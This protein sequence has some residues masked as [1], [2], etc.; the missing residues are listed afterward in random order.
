[1]TN[2]QIA[3]IFKL[4]GA[5]LELHGENPFKTKSYNNAYISLRKVGDPLML[6]SKDQL[7]LIPGVGKAIAEK[8]LEIQSTDTF[9]L[10]EELKMKTPPGVVELLGISGLGPKK[11]DII[12]KIMGIEDPGAL[13]YACTENR[14]IEYK[15]FGAKSQKTIEEKLQFYF[16]S[17]GK[18]LYPDALQYVNDLIAKLTEINTEGFIFTVGALLRKEQ[19]I[20]QIELLYISDQ[21]IRIPDDFLLRPLDNNRYLL[22][23][24]NHPE[25]F[26]NHLALNTINSDYFANLLGNIILE[27]VQ[28][29]FLTDP[30]SSINFRDLINSRNLDQFNNELFGPIFP[31]NSPEIWHNPM[32]YQNEHNLVKREDL[33][34]LVHLHTTYSDGINTLEEMIEAAIVRNFEYIV[35]TDHSKFAFYANGLSEDRLLIQL[36]QID[37]LNEKYSGIIKILKGIE[38]DILPDGSLDYSD[39]ILQ[40][41]DVVIIS[42]HSNLNMDKEKATNRLIKAIEN[43]YSNILGHPSG[44]V[45]L[46]RNGY[47]LDYDRIFE[48]C[49]NNNVHI[50]LNASPQRLDL[51]Y[52]LVDEAQNLGIKIC[53]NPD[54]HSISG[55]DHVTYGI[56]SARRGG[57]FKE[58]CLNTL[59]C[60]AFLEKLGKK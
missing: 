1:M 11:V 4:T 25:I 46:S 12:W 26:V 17:K 21:S 18:M 56:T 54:A 39:K 23:A 33:K 35:I 43:P 50:E 60:D 19:I 36:D 41:L 2:K 57:L 6:M 22:T 37:I 59:S 31:I 16:T 24:D 45:M 5:L 13:M 27:D 7:E 44:R 29:K 3:S 51:D 8:I 32:L 34:G 9:S 30:N 52:T 15:G 49:L 10:F 53:I 48:A 42:V 28:I 55:I 47:E 58:N 40:L 38:C 14:L 20:D